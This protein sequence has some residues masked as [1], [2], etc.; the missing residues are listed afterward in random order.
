MVQ[1]P[2]ITTQTAF[3]VSPTGDDGNAGSQEAPFAT[4]ARARDEVRKVNGAMSGDIIVHVT[5]GRY[6][7]DAPLTFDE[8]DSARNGHAIVYRGEGDAV[9]VGGQPLTQWSDAGD[10]VFTTPLGAGRK[11]HTLYE[12]GR[13]AT[14]ARRPKSGH[15]TGEGPVEGREKQA[16]YFREG[17]LDPSMGIEGKGI[18]FWPGGI[19]DFF[20]EIRTIARVDWERRIVELDRDSID[21]LGTGMRYFVQGSRA[22]LTEPGDFVVDGEAGVLTYWPFGSDPRSSEIVAPT[23]RNLLELV[24]SSP[25]TPVTGLTFEGLTLTSTE[26]D[27]VYNMRGGEA[28]NDETGTGRSGLVFM[29]NAESNTIRECLI[30]NAGFSAVILSRHAKRN[31][32]RDCRIRGIGFNGVY[33]AGWFPGGGPYESAEASD[34]NHSNIISNNHISDCGELVGQGSGIQLY[35]SGRNLVSHNEIHRIARYGISLKGNR[36]NLLR[37][38]MPT[39]FGTKL[40]YDNHWDFLHTRDNRVEFNDV[41][42]VMTNSQ[43]GGAIESWGP[44]K[45]NVIDHNRVHD[46]VCGAPGGAAIGLYMDDNSD[47]FTITNNIVYDVVGTRYYSVLVF[48]KGINNIV[49]NNIAVG[50]ADGN[51]AMLF[52]AHFGE[53]NDHLVLMNNIIYRPGSEVLYKFHDTDEQREETPVRFSEELEK[54]SASDFNV[55]FHPGG[56]YKIQSSPGEFTWEEWQAFEGRRFD[57]NSVIADPLF[58]DVDARNLSLRPESPALVRGFVNIDQSQIGLLPSFRA[59]WRGD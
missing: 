33:L 59:D 52:T 34:V 18:L 49:R 27:D 40:T 43:D 42:E 29:E 58:E 36:Y 3:Y 51:T 48:V 23:V 28:V 26:F 38:H 10:G 22:L 8:R 44:G 6:Y 20:I 9:L 24:G 19:W 50:A 55:F 12:N 45:G 15:F 13:R 54:L 11:V 56:S 39:P 21:P 7:H 4:V 57:R 5:A 2:S 37:D 16:F 30:T 25:E 46:V 41:Y 31:A 1:A 17:D 14:V 35:Q 32:V 53:R 47:F